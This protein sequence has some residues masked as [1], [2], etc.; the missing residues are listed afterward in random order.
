[1]NKECYERVQAQDAAKEEFNEL[2]IIEDLKKTY[3]NGVQAVKGIN[4][5]MFSNQIF[6][7]LGHNGAGK[8]STV[9]MLTGLYRATHGTATVFG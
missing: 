4:I 6:V 5:K 3:E 9:A 7:L 8:T 2:L 1:M